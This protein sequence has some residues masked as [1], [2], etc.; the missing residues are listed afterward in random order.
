MS[1]A[2]GFQNLNSYEWSPDLISFTADPAQTVVSTSYRGIEL[3]SAHR[4]HET[5][6]VEADEGFGPAY[7]VAGITDGKVCSIFALCI[8]AL[9]SHTVS[10]LKC[11]FSEFC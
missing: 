1:Y 5:V 2:P 6:P 11:S 10:S 3:F 4:Y 8:P 7:Y 9:R